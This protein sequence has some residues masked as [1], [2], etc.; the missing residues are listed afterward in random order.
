MRDRRDIKVFLLLF[1]QKK[2]ILVFF[3][4]VVCCRMHRIAQGYIR[5]G[6]VADGRRSGAIAG[7]GKL[8]GA[9]IAAGRC[10]L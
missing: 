8:S 4:A 5:E 3:S 7:G 6:E 9:A 1:L 2:K 10:A